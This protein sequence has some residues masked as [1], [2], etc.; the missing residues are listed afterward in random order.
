MIDLGSE[1][2]GCFTLDIIAPENTVVNIGYGEHLDDLRVRSSVGGRA[3]AAKYTCKAGRNRYTHYNKRFGCRYIELLI[4]AFQFTLLYA[5]IRPCHYPFAEAGKFHCSDSLHNKIYETSLK[6]LRLSA[7]EHYEDCPWREQALYAMDSRNQI[8]CGYYAFGE[9]RLPRES[10]RLLSMGLREDGLL[11]LCAPARVPVTIP[12]FS[13]IWILELYEY[14]LYSGDLSF[15]Y[16]MWPCAEK[17]IR[18]FWRSSRGRDLQGPLRNPDTWNF[19]E[20]SQGLSDGFPEKLRDKNNPEN[21]DGPLSVFY[22]L[23]LQCMVKLAKL[24]Y[25]HHITAPAAHAPGVEEPDFLEKISWCELLCGAAESA[26]HRTFWDPETGAYCSYVVNGDQVHFS[27]LM[28]AL[29]LY[30]ELVPETHVK[31]VADL[32]SGRAECAPGL[33]PVTLSYAIFKYEALLKAG[34]AYADAVFQDIAEKWGQMLYH[35]A[36]AFWETIEGAWAFG[37]AGSLCHGWSAIPVLIYYKYLLGV[38]PAACGFT[39]YQFQPVKLKTPIYASGEIP[40]IHQAPFHVETT[41]SG[42]QIS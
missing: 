35:N 30:A 31:R 13:L 42:F 15:A 33:I 12:S 32:L 1:E 28:N 14:V 9:Y 5:G 17:I 38:S 16:E 11:E 29:A 27:E 6:T 34:N 4:E 36:T 23:A 40:R 19:Y 39:D 37:N 22:I 24:L 21:F 25:S 8:L 3:F 18:A 26:F 7:H 2:C 20:W 41:P 10:I